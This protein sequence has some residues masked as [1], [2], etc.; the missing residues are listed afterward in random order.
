MS[1]LRQLYQ[2]V[3]LDHNKRPRH[4]GAMADCTHTAEG[5]NPICGDH[6]H[7]YL[8]M[9]GD[10]IA[11]I[12]FDGAGCAISKASASMMA[13]AVTG[14][15]RVE[16]QA[17]YDQVHRMLTGEAVDGDALGSIA[18]LEG[19][20]D[21][22]TRIKCATLAWHTLKNAMTGAAASASTEGDDS[23]IHA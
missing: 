19:V 18:V 7:V 1:D 22:P 23:Q 2:E 20:R 11:G 13:A 14:L 10:R 21:Y 4:F 15:T 9:D 16:A 8:K 17:L 6:Y 12:R 3:I 5:Y